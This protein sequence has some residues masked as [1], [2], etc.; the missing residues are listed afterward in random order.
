MFRQGQEAAA[1]LIRALAVPDRVVQL[2][3]AK[4]LIDATK[5]ADERITR[6]LGASFDQVRWEPGSPEAS[7][8]PNLRAWYEGPD[9]IDA[10][11]AD[12]LP[13]TVPA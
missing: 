5:R 13:L 4:A 6:E 7:A 10:E 9:A 1:R 11:P 8:I 12:Y 3:I 2:A